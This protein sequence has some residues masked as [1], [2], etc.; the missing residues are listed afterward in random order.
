MEGGE[1][2][3][4]SLYNATKFIEALV[5]VDELHTA[6]TSC[7][8]PDAHDTLFSIGVC[9]QIVADEIGYSNLSEIFT[10]SIQSALRDISEPT[11]RSMLGIDNE[12]YGLCLPILEELKRKAENPINFFDYYSGS[13]YITDANSGAKV[14]R[15]GSGLDPD[16]PRE[17]HLVQYLLRTN[18]AM[19]LAAATNNFVGMPYHPHSHRTNYVVDKLKRERSRVRFDPDFLLRCT[20]EGVAA[21]NRELSG[22]FG[23][24]ESEAHKPLI[25]TAMSGAASREDILTRAL[26]LRDLSEARL[27]RKFVAELM[28]AF[29]TGDVQ[30]RVKAEHDLNEAKAVL[31]RELDKLYG[32]R[33]DDGIGILPEM[34]GGAVEEITSDAIQDMDPS[35]SAER[36]AAKLAGKATGVAISRIIGS[37][38]EIAGKLKGFFI[39]RRIAF[40][41]TLARQDGGNKGINDLLRRS[42]GQELSHEQ[43]D[44]FKKMN[45]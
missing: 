13:V 30:A 24:S 38:K 31:M 37:K 23:F 39:R 1:L 3:A 27:Y 9:R 15:T 14:Q 25:M 35:D 41:L 7:W 40:L 21:R 4:A 8:E 44:L 12:I 33:Q 32:K 5:T 29:E 36:V 2:D 22:S 18:V 10:K 19:E 20:S 26:E 16:A 6:P 28:N 43:M 34:I 45:G 17:R 42:F 11:V